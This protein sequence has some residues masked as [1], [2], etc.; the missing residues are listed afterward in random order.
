[1][2]QVQRLLA[3]GRIPG[4][5]KLGHEYLLPADAEKPADPRKGRIERGEPYHINKNKTLSREL[6]EVLAALSPF[7]MPLDKPYSM[8]DAIRDKSLR[9]LPEM[10]LAY[11]KGDF[12]FV[13]RSYNEIEENGAKKLIASLT[14]IA[15]AISLGDYPFFLEVESYL[16][17][18]VKA[19]AGAEATAYAE[20]GLSIA[21]T[22]AV[23]LNMLPE[24]LKTG[25]FGALAPST[26]AIAAYVR[27][28]YLEQQK[29]PAVTLAAAQAYLSVYSSEKILT[30]GDTYLRILC[31]EACHALGRL[32]EAENYLQSAMKK[33]L[34]HGFVTA[35]AERL[36]HLGGLG[37]KLLMREFPSYHDAVIGQFDRV[38]RNW[39]VFHNRFTQDNITLILTIREIQIARLAAHGAPFKKIAEQFHISEGA[40]NNKMS[41]IYQ[42]LCIHGK[43]DLSNFIL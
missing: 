5:K 19:D 8:I 11:Q 43:S 26:R 41:V 23:A 33:N 9:V 21:Y 14:A 38:T 29:D 12:E 13:K 3:A 35:F 16:K 37:E 6:A 32:D 28:Q 10:W 31:A 20:L 17:S 4:G 24:W 7:Y 36:V 2:R 18:V 30:N 1:V 27:V 42:K 22:G 15:A 25:D 40:L 34:P 39:L